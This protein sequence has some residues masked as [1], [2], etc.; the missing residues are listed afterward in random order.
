MAAS[1]GD[2]VTWTIEASGGS[3]P[4]TYKWLWKGTTGDYVEIDAAINPTAATASLINHAV[5]TAS[6]GSY[7]CEVTDAKGAKVESV[8]SVLT[9]A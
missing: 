9:V 2:D 1:V 7:K 3:K 8:V 5:T 6:S 4:Y